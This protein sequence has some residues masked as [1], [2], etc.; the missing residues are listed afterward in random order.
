MTKRIMAYRWLTRVAVIGIVV[1]GCTPIPLPLHTTVGTVGVKRTPLSAG[2]VMP[3]S[4]RN[5]T[6]LQHVPCADNYDVPI[7]TEL[8][9]GAM[10][11]LAQAFESVEVVSDKVL[12]SGAYDTVIELE[13]PELT[14]D[15]HC[16]VRRALWI[17][18]PFSLLFNPSDSFDAQAGVRAMVSDRNG[19][20]LMAETFKSK[21]HSKDTLVSKDESRRN[22][23][24]IAMHA[25]LVD[26]IERMTQGMAHSAKLRAYAQSLP[27]KPADRLQAVEPRMARLSDVDDIG[28][29]LPSTR[30]NNSYAVLIGIEQYRQRLPR[31]DF[32]AYDAAI[33]REYL[34]KRLGY[35][36]EN[37]VTLLNEQA[38]RSDLEK[39]IERWL[40]N[41]VDKDSTVFVY[42]SGHG[43]PNPKTSEAYL[44]P[45]DGDPTFLEITAYPLKRLY[46]QLS[47]LPAKEI[48]VALDSCFSGSGS[49]S[50]VAKGTR[51]V[52][53]SQENPVFSSGKT[54]ILTASSNDQVSNT[55][56]K[57]AHG[58][59]TYYFL[60][61]LRGEA[62][63][64]HDNTIDLEE[65]YA[66]LKRGVERIARRDFNAEQ[67]PQ[68]FGSPDILKR[69]VRLLEPTVQ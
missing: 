22:A 40:P 25:A 48:I 61:G 14:V 41:H 44:V 49:R 29:T 21:T 28:E 51:P 69:G 47:K 19:H 31:V 67:T 43:A 30:N 35:P 32:G 24:A 42:Y 5:A 39:Y 18:G 45:Y 26:A 37:V 63:Q 36:E 9:K 55:Y 10:Q 34:T 12:A 64:N 23:V 20:V 68:M 1:T 50:V 4:M 2:L 13:F 66:Y 56:D 52:V 11:G 58:L 27:G 54:V 59:F 46:G 38:G 65:L 17:L 3:D 6:T 7:G 16:G 53:V 33:M 62:D 57:K 8:E 15:G 60:K